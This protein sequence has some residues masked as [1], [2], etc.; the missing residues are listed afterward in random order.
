MSGFEV[1]HAFPEE[2]NSHAARDPRLI[3]DMFIS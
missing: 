1:V 3:S 2:M